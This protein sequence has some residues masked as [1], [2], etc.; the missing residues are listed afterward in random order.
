MRHREESLELELTT[1]G[2][3]GIRLSH[4]GRTVDAR[5]HRTAPD[6]LRVLIDDHEVEAGLHIDGNVLTVFMFGETWRFDL[7]DHLSEASEGG[8]DEDEVRAP[9]P[10]QVTRVLAAPGDEVTA[11]DALVSM[12][13]MKMEQTLPAPRDGAVES[14]HVQAGDQVEEGAVLVTLARAQE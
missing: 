3:G 12:E 8:Q 7:P 10:G 1:E 9:M 13:A 2:D 5:I 14:V 6:R 4:E 11:G